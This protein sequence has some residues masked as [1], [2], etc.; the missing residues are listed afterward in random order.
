MGA[1][2]AARASSYPGQRENATAYHAL[3]TAAIALRMH[4]IDMKLEMMHNLDVADGAE[5]MSQAA[6]FMADNAGVVAQ[7]STTAG[8]VEQIS[9][10]AA[11]VES[12]SQCFDP[13]CAKCCCTHVWSKLGN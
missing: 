10:T 12:G 11:A 1:M 3:D 8:V 7:I 2:R 9:T 5:P 4:N 13:E 6:G